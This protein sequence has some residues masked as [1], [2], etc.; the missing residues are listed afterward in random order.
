MGMAGVLVGLITKPKCTH[1]VLVGC[2]TKSK[3]GRGKPFGEKNHQNFCILAKCL[4]RG[5]PQAAFG[6]GNHQIEVDLVGST[7]KLN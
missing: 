1:G 5:G 4:E 2:L 3:P 7:I 6:D